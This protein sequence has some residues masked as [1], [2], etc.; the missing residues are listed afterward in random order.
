MI[1]RAS[2]V[3]VG[4]AGGAVYAAS[5]GFLPLP[6]GNTTAPAAPA[7]AEVDLLPPTPAPTVPAAVTA[8]VVATPPAGLQVPQTAVEAALTLPAT[9]DIAPDLAEAQSPL[10][11]TADDLDPT[12]QPVMPPIPGPGPE[13]SQAPALSPLGLPCGLSVTGTAQPA[14]MVALDIM[15]PCQ[16]N[17]PVRI[18]HSGMTIGATTDA[19]GLLTIDIPAFETPAF[20]T[21]RMDD[22]TEESLLVAL[23]DLREFDRIGV[24]WTD[25]AELDL[26]AMEFGARFGD[27]GHVWA[28]NPRATDA[29]SQGAGGFL[30][31]L[32]DPDMTDRM[33][34]QVYTLPR[35]TLSQG[36]SVRI[37]LD[38]EITEANC[39]RPAEA[40]TL[41]S[42]A[43]GP[44]EITPLTFTHP[45][46]D[47]VGDFLV[48][49]NLL[50]DLRLASN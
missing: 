14:A 24:S 7:Q 19:M 31:Q 25:Q 39:T 6:G 10:Q 9:D 4:L 35:A 43:A 36:N 44:V 3:T 5:Q 11:N 46:C 8:A 40:L 47:A 37:T 45:D 42:E 38:A 33:L 30:T 2:A 20:F 28:E 13:I 21:V 16:P 34:A 23:P 41:R 17:A 26:H 12:P 1:L 15:D 18:A 48:L 29:V 49:Q 32:G 22:G 27:D 50:G